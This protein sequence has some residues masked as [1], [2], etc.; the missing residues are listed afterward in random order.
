MNRCIK[1]VSQFKQVFKAYCMMVKELKLE[2]KRSGSHLNVSAKEK[3]AK[4][5]GNFFLEGSQLFTE[6]CFLREGL[7]T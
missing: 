4:K 2:K 3:N 1:I 6:F 7:G 5:Y